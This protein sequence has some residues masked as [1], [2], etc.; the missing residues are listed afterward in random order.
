MDPALS[1]SRRMTTVGG[2]LAEEKPR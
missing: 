1:L 2:I